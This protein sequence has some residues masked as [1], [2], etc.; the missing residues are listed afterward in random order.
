MEELLRKLAEHRAATAN[1]ALMR[2]TSKSEFEFGRSCGYYQ[3]I[4]YAIEALES[5]LSDG[6][7]GDD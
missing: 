4:T 7:D 5:L 2:P 6:D 3:G 1:D